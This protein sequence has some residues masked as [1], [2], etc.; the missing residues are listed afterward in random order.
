MKLPRLSLGELKLIPRSIWALG[1]VSLLMDTASESI[2]SLLPV[3]MVTTL[4]ASMTFVGIIEGIAEATALLVR[5]FSGVVSDM[6]GRHK[7]LTM[8]G[9]ALAALSKPLFPLATS[10]GLVF[11]ARFIDRVGKGIRG[12][13]RDALMGELSPREIRGACFGLRQSMDTIG[14]F[15]G[16]L[17]AMAGMV[18]FAYDLRAVLWLAV[19]PAMLALVMLW[20]GV[21]EPARAQGKI[22]ESPFRFSAFRHGHAQFWRIVALAGILSLAR[23]S[24][25]F[26]II[27]AQAS[28]VS[29]ALVPLVLI[30]MN[31]VYA[32][33]SYPAG[34]ISDRVGRKIVLILGIALLIVANVTLA[35]ASN[36]IVIFL[37]I[38]L[39][40][41]HLGCTQGLFAAL[42]TDVT[43]A[44]IRG[45]AFG[46][47]NLV[48]GIAM[49]IASVG[50]GLLWDNFSS[51][52]MFSTGAVIAGSAL[53]VLIIFY[54]GTFRQTKT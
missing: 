36:L 7:I 38:A 16:P 35:L 45:T 43:S 49:L 21:K 10:M 48:T 25:A 29:L 46:I 28:G 33:F 5:I 47:F 34:L 4:G 23:Y 52:L 12:A 41:M 31:V 19:I 54:D 14:A 24:E 53:A 32:A 3:F 51:T 30:F 9:Y 44:P 22:R 2:H 37:G 13:P 42:I 17:M 11:T 26:L 8:V 20:L 39:F 18:L 6:F 27:K 40:G 15:L 50:A 1:L